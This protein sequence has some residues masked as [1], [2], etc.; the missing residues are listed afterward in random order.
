MPSCVPL[1]YYINRLSI[2]SNGVLS[3]ISTYTEQLNSP[4]T[5]NNG[6]GTGSVYF[7]KVF[8]VTFVGYYNNYSA[9]L[10]VKPGSCFNRE[11]STYN[12]TVN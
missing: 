6:T 3:R 4:L 9:G 11:G 12:N 1:F 7:R 10:I 8:N 5:G 2:S